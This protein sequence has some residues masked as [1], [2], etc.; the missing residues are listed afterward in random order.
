[1][2]CDNVDPLPDVLA[3]RFSQNAAK[4]RLAYKR[5]PLSVLGMTIDLIALDTEPD[6]NHQYTVS[7]V[8]GVQAESVC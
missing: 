1:M 3:Q 5:G 7:I 6:C 2:I 4:S 8:M